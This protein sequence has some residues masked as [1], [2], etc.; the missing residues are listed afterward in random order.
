MHDISLGGD[1][2]AEA[3]NEVGLKKGKVKS[4]SRRSL[5]TGGLLS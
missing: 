1:G 3:V 2:E 4:I 5:Q